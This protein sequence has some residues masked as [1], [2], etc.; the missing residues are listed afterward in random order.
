MRS[1]IAVGLALGCATT[2]YY[3]FYKGSALLLV[4]LCSLSLNFKNKTCQIQLK[5]RRLRRSNSAPALLESFSPQPE[6]I[7]SIAQPLLTP[8]LFLIEPL[9][10]KDLKEKEEAPP[11]IEKKPVRIA[12][13]PQAANGFRSNATTLSSCLPDQFNKFLSRAEHWVTH[14]S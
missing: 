7:R 1:R 9:K 11:V 8:Q 5:E 10:E 13:P 14:S 6:E 2:L 4:A 3:E 12:L